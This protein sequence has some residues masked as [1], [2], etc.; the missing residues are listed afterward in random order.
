MD[1]FS[2]LRVVSRASMDF[3]VSFVSTAVHQT[4]RDLI[5]ILILMT[6]SV[7]NVAH[8]NQNSKVEISR[9]YAGVHEPE[10]DEERRPVSRMQVAD[11]LGIHRET[12]RR[13]INALIEDGALIQTPEGLLASYETQNAERSLSLGRVN[14]MLVRRMIR[15]L[16]DNGVNV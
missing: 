13:R 6:V 1:A 10:P 3:L 16:K 9:Q 4:N 11:T 15:T 8:L 14:L 12:A 2:D 7:S 5:D